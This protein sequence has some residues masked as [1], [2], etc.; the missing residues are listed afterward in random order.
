[1]DKSQNKT[2]LRENDTDQLLQ[3]PILFVSF[4][5]SIRL[6]VH[7]SNSNYPVSCSGSI[8]DPFPTVYLASLEHGVSFQI[9]SHKSEIVHATIWTSGRT[10]TSN[11]VC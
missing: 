8:D 3:T 1:M 11:P 7:W 5:I 9:I 4:H 2:A 6:P 10:C